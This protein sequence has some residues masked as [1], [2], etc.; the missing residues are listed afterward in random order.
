MILFWQMSFSQKRVEM[1]L[2]QIIDSL[3][4]ELA[5]AQND[6]IR[7]YLLMRVGENYQNCNPDSAIYYADKSILLATKVNYVSILNA[8]YGFQAG[9]YLKQ[10][11]LPKSLELCIRAF[12]TNI[13]LPDSLSG[14]G[15]ANHHLGQIYMS[16]GE[17]KKALQ[18]FNDIIKHGEIVGRSFGYMELANIYSDLGKLDSALL[19]IN[20]SY[21]SFL[22]I[23][24]TEWDRNHVVDPEL[25]IIKSK[26][27]LMRGESDLALEALFKTLELT[28]ENNEVVYISR[29]YN[30][31]AKYYKNIKAIDSAIYYSKKG[32]EKAQEINYTQEILRSS[33]ILADV[34]ESID[35]AIALHYYKLSTES[36]ETLYGSGNIQVMKDMIVQNESRKQ[37]LLSAELAFKNRLRINILLG[38]TFTFIVIAILL[39]RNNKSKQNAKVKIEKAYDQLKSTQTQLIQSEKMASLGELTAGIAHEIQNPLNFVNNFS[40]VSIDLIGELKEEQTKKKDKRD[41][42]LEKEI[43]NDVIQNLEKI[44]HHGLRASSIVKGMLEH[45]RSSSK[46]KQLIDINMLADEYL[47]LAYHGLR[48]KDKSFNADFS[49]EKD[50]KLPEIKVIP[51]D[52]GRVLL[53]LINNA[54]Y[55]VSNK[56][57]EGVKNF[58]PQV[59]VS[60]QTR[61]MAAEKSVVEIRVKDNGKGIP[62]D[63]LDKIFQP[64]F[65]TKPTGEGTGLGLSLSYDIIKAHGGEIKVDSKNGEGTEFAIRIPYNL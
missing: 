18:V 3:K 10:G 2:P 64:F 17:Y 43:L 4:T 7:A 16:L 52:I 29:A 56:A 53:N 27:H 39:F 6:S 45:S 19:F 15:P 13:D 62:K 42:L 63:I 31:L 14:I 55:A 34:Y 50:D 11:N 37:E 25:Y 41:E 8:N 40:D 38:S 1:T 33:Q 46:E 21:D 54:F 26:V 47:R 35:L 9:A 12:E 58:K 60:T 51:Q 44:N 59:I 30:D 24:T 22:R 5:I 48:A 36:K 49:L 32:L 61:D 20:F 57:K 28:L 65:T 23:K